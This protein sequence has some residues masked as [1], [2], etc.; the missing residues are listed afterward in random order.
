LIIAVNLNMQ[1]N[2]LL[3]DLK[4]PVARMGLI[5]GVVEFPL[6]LCYKILNSDS[7][8]LLKSSAEI[9]VAGIADCS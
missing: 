5:I 1:Q 7:F 4:L 9:S 6:F 3:S 2:G 8:I